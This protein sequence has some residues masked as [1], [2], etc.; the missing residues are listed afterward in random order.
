MSATTHRRNSFTESHQ[1]IVIKI[2]SPLEMTDN[3]KCLSLELINYYGCVLLSA[4]S[5]YQ[6]RD[7]LLSLT[8]LFGQAMP[9]QASDKDGVVTVTPTDGAVYMGLT[10]QKFTIHTDGCYLDNP[11]KYFALQ[12]EIPSQNGGLSQLVQADLLY[13]Y[14][15]RNYSSQLKGMFDKDAV[16]IT[17]LDKT[18]FQRPIFRQL[19]DRFYI[20]FR[21]SDLQISV[22]PR[23]DIKDAFA[24]LLNYINDPS[25]QLL[26][27]LSANDILVADNAR[28]LHGRTAFDEQEQPKR[29][30]HRLWMNGISEYSNALTP[31][32]KP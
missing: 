14:L 22:V 10:A 32:F 19:D 18:V 25:H 26:L 31:G 23:E 9:Y 8:G 17:R 11:P 4:R 16:T 24:A 2:D 7:G 27:K 13:N 5:N 6:L 20:F 3:Q 21:S 30:L 12:C 29:R 1:D 28:I 15:A